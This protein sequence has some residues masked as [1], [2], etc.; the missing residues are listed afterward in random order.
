MK[1]T[2]HRY[3]NGVCEYKVDGN[4]LWVTRDAIPESCI[5]DYKAEL[6]VKVQRRVRMRSSSPRVVLPICG[7]DEAIE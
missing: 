4:G 6:V 1:V 3:K 2:R 7:G 5:E